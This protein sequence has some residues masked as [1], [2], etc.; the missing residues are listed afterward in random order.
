MN[1]LGILGLVTIGTIAIFQI[2]I[3]DEALDPIIENKVD[4]NMRV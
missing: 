4:I 2:L 1:I 3:L